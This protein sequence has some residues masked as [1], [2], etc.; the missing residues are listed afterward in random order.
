MLIASQL[1][2]AR[3]AHERMAR[4]D[5]AKRLSTEA[6]T[7]SWLSARTAI[8]PR[9]IEAMRRDGELIAVRPP[10]SSEHYYP[11]WQFDE[12]WRPLPGVERVT[13]A[14]RE[15]GLDDNRLYEVLSAR[16]GLGGEQRLGSALRAGNVDRVLAAIRSARA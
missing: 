3:Y 9:L 16:L 1:K 13:A 14:A 11:L 7:G 2:R 10:G 5:L 6:L 15:R 8:E 12:N 4:D